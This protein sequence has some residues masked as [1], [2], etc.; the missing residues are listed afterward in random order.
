MITSTARR[1]TPT[2]KPVI[3]ALL[4]FV[5]SEKKVN[6]HEIQYTIKFNNTCI[7]SL[8]DVPQRYEHYEDYIH[9]KSSLS[10]SGI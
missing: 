3:V 9:L 5:P 8:V 4:P 1:V 2:T 7:F 6:S 10:Y